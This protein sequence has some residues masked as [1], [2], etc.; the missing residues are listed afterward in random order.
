MK[1]TLAAVL[2]VGLMLALTGA[3]QAAVGDPIDP[4]GF[5]ADADSL[6][7]WDGPART[8]IAAFNGSGL[9]GTNH[10]GGDNISNSWFTQTGV[11]SEPWTA[12]QRWL[13]VNMGADY[14]IGQLQIW[15]Y[16]EPG[17]GGP[18]GGDRGAKDVSIWYQTSAGTGAIPVG[19]GGDSQGQAFVST[20]WTLLGDYTLSKATSDPT[21]IT[22]ALDPADFQARYVLIEIHTNYATNGNANET[23]IGEVRFLEGA[24]GDVPEPATMSLLAIGGAAALIRRRIHAAS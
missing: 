21:G 18:D 20:G 14:A 23:G 5:T 4:A 24:V 1:H 9:S 13:M 10:S 11:G 19:S 17:W 8:P 2:A 22:D 6:Y 3:A 15:N 12:G 16:N 7:P